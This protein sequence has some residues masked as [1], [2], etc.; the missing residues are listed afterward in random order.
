MSTRRNFFRLGVG[1][2]AA[3]TLRGIGRAQTHMAGM[4]M[5][6]SLE[7][8]V[9]P[10][11]IPSVLKP[12]KKGAIDAYTMTMR[13]AVVKCHRDLPPTSILGY[14]G[15]YPGPTIRAT[16]G[17]TVQVTHINNLPT[18]H[19]GHSVGTHL[20]AIHLHGALVAPDSDGHPHD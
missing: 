1:A 6:P 20:P 11:P 12:V 7:P 14:N 8:F 4:A 3:A 5:T 17:R 13:E 18:N 16:K 19:Q 15:L 9:D 10:L 2:A